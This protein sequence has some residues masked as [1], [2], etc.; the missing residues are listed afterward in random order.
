[1]SKL[2]ETESD[3]LLIVFEYCSIS[4]GECAGLKLWGFGLIETVIVPVYG[5]CL[6]NEG[7]VGLLLP[8]D[9]FPIAEFG[10][11]LVV[12][13]LGDA[14][15]IVREDGGLLNSVSVARGFVVCC[16]GVDIPAVEKLAKDDLDLNGVLC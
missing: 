6:T 13:I 2:Y 1:M 9:R 15:L 14:G 8:L 12:V 3:L 16:S 7:V 4:Q 5:T 11:D 10:L